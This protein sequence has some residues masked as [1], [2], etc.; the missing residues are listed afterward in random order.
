MI[1]ES[2]NDQMPIEQSVISEPV[3][4]AGTRSRKYRCGFDTLEARALFAG[5]IHGALTH[6]VLGSATPSTATAHIQT[7]CF[8]GRQTFFRHS[9]IQV[10]NEK[11]GK[12]MRS[13]EV[14]TEQVSTRDANPVASRRLRRASKLVRETTRRMRPRSKAW[15]RRLSCRPRQRPRAFRSSTT[16]ARSRFRFSSRP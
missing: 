1:C 13:R 16:A 8:V 9:S 7:S 15:K 6:D 12:P 11:V 10:S 5:D 2:L 4:V 14:F 3:R